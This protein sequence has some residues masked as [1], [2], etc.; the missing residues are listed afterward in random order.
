MTSVVFTA[1]FKLFHACVHMASS[2]VVYPDT[3]FA[4]L[5]P[6]RSAIE[7]SGGDVTGGNPRL[8]HTRFWLDGYNRITS[9]VKLSGGAGLFVAGT[10]CQWVV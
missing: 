9:T 6:S 3:S 2:F 8:D 7:A 1:K 10:Q 4:K 5:R